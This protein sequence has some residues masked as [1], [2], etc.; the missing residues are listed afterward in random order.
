MDDLF[1]ND[2]NV[3]GFNMTGG[4]VSRR[5]EQIAIMSYFI[6]IIFF[7]VFHF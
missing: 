5:A 4:P 3:T 6:S 2:S 1:S 7:A